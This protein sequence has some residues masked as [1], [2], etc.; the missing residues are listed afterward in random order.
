VCPFCGIIWKEEK[1]KGEKN[2]K[3]NLKN[4]K[5]KIKRM[6]MKYKTLVYL[7]NGGFSILLIL[8]LISLIFFTN[9]PATIYFF[10]SAII[11]KNGSI[12]LNDFVCINPYIGVVHMRSDIDKSYL[13]DSNDKEI[14]RLLKYKFY[15]AL[16]LIPDKTKNFPFRLYKD[17]IYFKTH[18]LVYLH[19]LRIIG[20]ENR[21]K[22]IYEKLKEDIV[23]EKMFKY[24]LNDVDRLE[25]SDIDNILTPVLKCRVRIKISDIDEFKSL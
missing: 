25:E 9:L 15:E 5:K 20:R 24:D 14:E 4:K 19:L 2:L 22:I 11:V 18:R 10:I 8:S 1:G 7:N 16:K 12:S 6:I 13:K 17:E 23:T 3:G 21:N